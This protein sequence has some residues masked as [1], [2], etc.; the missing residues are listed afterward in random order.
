VRGPARV[1]GGER[2]ISAARATVAAP[3]LVVLSSGNGAGLS[4]LSVAG[5]PVGRRIALAAGRAGFGEV[6]AAGDER[7]PGG[8]RR[9]VAL[10]AH[11]VPQAAWLR[12]L[13]Q[14]PLARETLY[15]DGG[16]VA[17]IDTDEP[18]RVLEAAAASHGA[19]EL[20]RALAGA[21]PVVRGPLEPSGRFPLA[22]AADVAAAE[23][24]LL[25]SL[26]K[27]SE[28]FMSR[29][30]ERRIS[31][32]VTRRLCDTGVTPNAMTVV[33]V[34][35]GLCGAL[36]FLS[37]ASALQTIGALLFLAHS[38]LDGCDGELARLK[39]LE[40]R[41]GAVLDFWGDNLVHVAVFGCMAVGWAMDAGSAWPLVLG[42]VTVVSALAT[43]T[44]ASRR[45]IGGETTQAASPAARLA[46]ALSHRD[47]I[48]FIV[49]LSLFGKAH[50][51][52]PIAAVGTPAF[53]LFLFLAS[54][55]SGA[56]RRP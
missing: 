49:A 37:P 20:A 5:L 7:A 50:W 51:F 53:L 26:I 54:R 38:I 24:W 42:G 44:V 43:A 19:D 2:L 8:P 47:F 29:H 3:L 56:T 9:I 25:R 11:V 17:V 35:I 55:P 33:S 36:F 39:F 31:L 16:A 15:V 45:F 21:L 46:E 28:G 4:G 10:G 34:G 23:R 52:L 32:A 48:Y 12:T 27:P 6:R 18:A 14:M 30:V 41:A 22:G 40:S 13:A 1:G